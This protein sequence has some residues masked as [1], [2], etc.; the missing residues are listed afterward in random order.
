MNTKD[1][2]LVALRPDIYTEP[3]DNPAEQFQ[4]QVLRPILKFQHQRIIAV[5]RHHISKRKVPLDGMAPD[6]QKK[7]VE[8][9][10]QKDLALRNQL[11]GVVLGLLTDEEWGTFMETER[12]LSRRMHN[13]LIQRIQ[14]TLG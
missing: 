11:V 6:D 2:N 1:T 14:S 12:E 5:F 8:K 9:S 4:N 7:Y 13:L 10:F 3:T